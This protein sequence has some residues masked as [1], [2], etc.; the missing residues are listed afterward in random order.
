MPELIDMIRASVWK[1][2][3]AELQE[4]AEEQASDETKPKRKAKSEKT[5]Q[6]QSEVNDG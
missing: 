5:V 4:Q 6:D 1:H 2:P 3:Q